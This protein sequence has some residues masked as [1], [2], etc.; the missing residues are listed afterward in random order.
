EFLSVSVNQGVALGEDGFVHLSYSYM[1]RKA[2]NRAVP[3]AD[4]VRLYP[5]LPGGALDPREA[6]IDRLVTR[7]YGAFPQTS[8]VFGANFGYD[9]SGG[10][11]FYGFATYGARRS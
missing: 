1:D 2:S 4:S 3:I 6:T 8:H 11:E 5:L 9:L 7:N 10:A